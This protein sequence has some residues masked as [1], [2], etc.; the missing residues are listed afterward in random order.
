MNHLTQSFSTRCPCVSL[1]SEINRYLLS[2]TV[3]QLK[4]VGAFFVLTFIVCLPIQFQSLCCKCFAKIAENDD[5]KNMMLE[6]ACMEYNS[7]MAEC[8]LLLGADINKKT[9]TNSLIYQV[10]HGDIYII[11]LLKNLCFWVPYCC[12]VNIYS[13]EHKEQRGCSH[14]P[15]SASCYMWPPLNLIF[16]FCEAICISTSLF[17]FSVE[18]FNCL[19]EP[20]SMKRIRKCSVLLVELSGW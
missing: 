9:K 13:A 8:L 12:H 4:N 11:L 5:L 18:V 16:F 14:M 1:T 6:K 3:P 20:H 19:R 17:W 15:T 7:I 10:I 2:L